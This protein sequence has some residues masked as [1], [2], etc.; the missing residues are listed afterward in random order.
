M[1]GAQ[2]GTT[3]PYLVWSETVIVVFHSFRKFTKEIIR[4]M[5]LR[6][7]VG[8]DRNVAIGCQC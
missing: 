4:Q 1:I 8:I 2:T 3:S 7:E 6:V 5:P